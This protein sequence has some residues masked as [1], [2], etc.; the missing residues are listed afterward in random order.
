MDVSGT[1]CGPLAVMGDPFQRGGRGGGGGGGGYVNG[2]HLEVMSSKTEHNHPVS[3]ATYEQLPKQR[4]LPEEVKGEVQE[5][6]K[7]KANKKL[8]KQKIQQETG[9]VVLLKDLSNLASSL[10]PPTKNDLQETV[11]MLQRDYGSDCHVLVSDNQFQGLL[12]STESMRKT[13]AAYPE[14]L[15]I[16]ATYK[17]LDLRTPVY[18][19]H[20]EDSNGSTEVVCIAILVTE[21]ACSLS[22]LNTLQE[23]RDHLAADSVYKRPAQLEAEE[24]LQ[25]Y[26]RRLTG[27]A[28]P[29]LKKQ[30][31]LSKS[32]DVREDNQ[33]Q[34]HCQSR[35]GE[36]VT[37]T[38]SCSCS[39]RQSMMSPCR[40]ILAV[41]RSKGLSLYEE[42]LYSQRWSRKYYHCKQRLFNQ[43]EPGTELAGVSVTPIIRKPK[44]QTQQQKYRAAFL[45]CKYLAE[46]ASEET[47]E[48]FVQHL[49]T[50]KTL[51]KEWEDGHCVD[52]V[53]QNCYGLQGSV[54]ADP[55]PLDCCRILPSPPIGQID[56]TLATA[57]DHLESTELVVPDRND[58]SSSPVD[59]ASQLPAD[60]VQQSCH[61]LQIN[62]DMDPQVLECCRN[63]P[64]PLKIHM[65]KP[66]STDLY[67][68]ENTQLVQKRNCSSPSLVIPDKFQHILRVLNTNIDGRRKVMFALTAIKGVGR[69]F[70]NM[71]CKKADVDL[72]KR[73]GELTEEEVEKLIT[74][75]SNPRQYKIPDWFLNR[76]KDIKDGKFSQ[77]TSNALEN[78]LREDL[79]R[80]KKIRAHRGLRHFWGLR[81]RGQ[82]T[83]T[84]GRRGRTVGVSKKKN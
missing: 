58:S 51:I 81:V 5:L 54:E 70:S 39:F 83:K 22:V 18:V 15:G 45:L 1:P 21:D 71:V 6:I 84:T 47:N 29:F 12:I 20:N 60:V 77:V 53:Q 72:N 49:A 57:L 27:Y 28:F 56:G 32:V 11:E 7:L 82:H 36:T 24:H 64:S 61:G 17:L 33:G 46:L 19:I 80:L 73:A 78:K 10:K 55:Q 66:M 50:L 52:V 63:S 76:Q 43:K 68:P 13:M 34:Y 3:K 75:M 40:H 67:H 26:Q 42:G 69:R 9:R 79:E 4:A 74:I 38:A 48:R 41:R 62:D 37:T 2:E 14:F 35:S 30:E 25:Q 16:D 31:E 8:I 23:E 65:D 44:P 59:T